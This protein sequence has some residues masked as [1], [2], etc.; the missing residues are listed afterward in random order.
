LAGF[1]LVRNPRSGSDDYSLAAEARTRLTDVE[2]FDLDPRADLA[3]AIDRALLEDRVVV[4]AGGD[5][6]VNAVAQHLVARGT[7]GV[8]PGG[9]LNHF[10]R[11]LGVRDPARALE[12]LERGEPGAVDLGRVDGEFFVNGAG[13][14][15]YP[16]VVQEREPSRNLM[17]RLVASAGAS[18]RVLRQAEP[19]V[20]SVS[21][22]GDAR[23]L[24]A[25]IL[26]VGNNRF[27]TAP[28]RVGSRERLDEGVLDMRLLTLGPGRTP[29][30]LAWAVLR[31]R[32]WA[33]RRLVRAEAR[34]VEIDLTGRPRLL[35]VDGEVAEATDRL[36]IEIVPRA[37]RV[38]HP[39]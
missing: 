5:G 3:G 8:L 35:S 25:W 13:L 17:G 14:G 12:A 28:G 11:D 38:L 34:R 37:L 24:D 1:L 32:A 2:S 30:R 20:G 4:A 9:T 22:D 26:F 33:G 29:G 18:I 23:Q 6:T 39:A 21:A 15:L 7:M 36:T 19:L 27:G 31:D 10:A 16:E